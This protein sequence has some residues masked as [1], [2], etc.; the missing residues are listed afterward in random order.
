MTKSLYFVQIR[1]FYPQKKEISRVCLRNITAQKIAENE[2]I[3]PAV[4]TFEI[5]K[6]ENGNYLIDGVG[7]QAHLYTGDNQDQYFSTM[8]KIAELGLK[9]N[10]T[11]LDISMGTWQNIKKATAENLLEQ[12][13]YYY[14]LIEGILQRVEAGTVKMDA[15]TFWGYGDLLS[16]RGD[17][18][19]L[20]YNRAN[21]AKPALYGALQ[22]KELAGFEE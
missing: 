5:A 8:D 6:D 1:I 3:I 18:S 7:F 2:A 12:G 9:I 13:R 19:P 11:E 15:L 4:Q 20:L 22:I 21:K 10:L 17:R 16:W 14:N